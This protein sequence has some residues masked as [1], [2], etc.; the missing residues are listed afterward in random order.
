ML[1]AT[2]AK[3]L[4]KQLDTDEVNGLTTIF[5]V[6]GDPGRF[7]IFKLLMNR[8]ESLCVSEM[9]SLFNVSVPAASQQL[10]LMEMSGLVVPVREG[11]KICYELNEKNDYVKKICKLIG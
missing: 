6:L 11:Q 7:R 8:D 9:A 5:S 4:K 10:K 2:K 1:T 3:T